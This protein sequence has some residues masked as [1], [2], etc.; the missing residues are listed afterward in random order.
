MD[1]K[2][3]GETRDCERDPVCTARAFADLLSAPRAPR[4]VRIDDAVVFE[5]ASARVYS[6][7]RERLMQ[8]AQKWRQNTQWTVITVEGY[9]R[10]G[11][12]A[13]RRANKVRD[14]LVK[15]GIEAEL[16]VAVG[17]AGTLPK[18]HVDLTV[19]LCDRAEGACHDAKLA[20]K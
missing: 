14:Y 16:V 13:Q 7:S 3:H 10:D 18:G 2:P 12:L 1:L 11:E 19:D 20:I 6:A 9:A 15:Y 8:F 17:R 4:E 5:P